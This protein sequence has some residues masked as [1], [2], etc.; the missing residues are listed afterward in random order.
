M[1]WFLVD[2]ILKLAGVSQIVSYVI[3]LASNWRN[4]TKSTICFIYCSK[5]VEIV[6]F[7]E[8]L[9]KRIPNQQQQDIYFLYSKHM[10]IGS[11]LLNSGHV[12]CKVRY[13]SRNQS[14]WRCIKCTNFLILNNVSF[15]NLYILCKLLWMA[16]RRNG[17]LRGPTSSSYWGLQPLVILILFCPFY[18][19]LCTV[20]TFI[21]FSN[22]LSN[23]E[24]YQK[25]WN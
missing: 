20:V 22:N 2:F 10:I 11:V 21:T 14:T 8:A 17:P 9:V 19:I 23:F 4:C 24:K 13:C 15:T 16:S 3:L 12:F 7:F 25:V 18:A 5:E 6:L 1:Y